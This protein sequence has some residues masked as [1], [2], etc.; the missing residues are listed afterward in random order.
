M[1]SLRALLV[2][3][4]LEQWEAALVRAGIRT[5]AHLGAVA[6]PGDLPAEL[7]MSARAELATAASE[8]RRMAFVT[9]PVRPMATAPADGV[10]NCSLCDVTCL[11]PPLAEL[12]APVHVALATTALEARR[13]MTACLACDGPA[14]AA[15][16][17]TPSAPCE[18]E[19]GQVAN[20]ISDGDDEDEEE[21]PSCA[22]PPL[23]RQFAAE[24]EARN[25]RAT[26]R[27][28]FPVPADARFVLLD[29]ERRVGPVSNHSLQHGGEY[30]LS[31]R[32][33]VPAVGLR[34]GDGKRLD[35]DRGHLVHN[36]GLEPGVVGVVEKERGGRFK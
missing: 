36:V 8:A 29:S 10:R 3:I 4:R 17:P 18:G 11:T 27:E 20:V 31:V 16:Q 1:A 24:E 22:S 14:A 33:V 30:Q 19:K 32:H 2:T 7:P 9:A 12:P 15:P 26:I 23:P 28:A 6:T 5:V 21:P 35:A 34:H 13:R 25:I